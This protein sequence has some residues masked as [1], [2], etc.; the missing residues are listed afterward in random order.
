MTTY[1]VATLARYTLVKAE[2]EGQARELGR[3]GL[4]KLHADVG[5][6]IGKEICSVDDLLHQV[7]GQGSCLIERRGRLR[8]LARRSFGS[9]VAA[10]A[11]AR[12]L[13]RR[14][15]EQPLAE[16]ALL[17]LR[18]HRVLSDCSLQKR[19]RPFARQ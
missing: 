1:Y 10:S 2:N 18:V 9:A 12:V 3:V 6:R 17:S 4:E 11:V 13:L 7:L 5:R 15:K 16:P 19:I 8:L 14:L